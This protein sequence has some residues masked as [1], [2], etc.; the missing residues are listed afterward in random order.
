MA[1]YQRINLDTLVQ[2]LTERLG[3]NE[4]FWTYNE[5]RRALNEA[6]RVW[7]VMSGQWSRRFAIPT[8][9]GQ[10]FYDVPRQL[11]SLQ[12][13]KYDSTPLWPSSVTELDYGY[14]NW[15]QSATG[16][17]LF[18]SPIGLGMIVINPPA[19]A[20]HFLNMEGMALL[21]ALNVGGDFI[22]IGDEEVNRILDYAH[23]TLTFKEGGLEFEATLPL[24]G[25]FVSAA[26]LGN[27]R[28]LGVSIFKRNMGM[29]K[30]EEQKPARSPEQIIG[31]RG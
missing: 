23:H 9:A 13:V 18:W 17:P 2:R 25:S 14:T 8:V 16:T 15:Q 28:L 5:K 31:A 21:P 24:M 20:G 19:P 7:A 10:R 30:D 27:Q 4:T 26:G 29:A 1:S 11:V 3:L 12:R 6:L 22:D